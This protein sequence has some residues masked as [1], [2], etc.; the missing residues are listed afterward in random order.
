MKIVQEFCVGNVVQIGSDVWVIVKMEYNKLGCNVVVVKMKMKNLLLNV[1]QELV[2]KVDDKFDVVV[3]D[4]KEVMYLYFVDLM[5]VFM[6]VDY[7]QY[8]VEVEMMGEV[9]N[10][11]EDGMVC[12]VVFYNEKVILVELLMIFVCEIIYME[13]VVK[14]DMLLGKVLKNVKL[15][16]GFELQVLL[17]CN[18]GDK[19]EIDMCMNEYCSC[20]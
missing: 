10:Y 4:C 13:L 14:G 8:E 16:I 7:N 12:E 18:I 11:F 1:G 6:D 2:Y 15:V 20:V 9:L 3:F 17:F 5:Y 19:I